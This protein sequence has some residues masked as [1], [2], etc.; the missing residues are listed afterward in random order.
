MSGRLRIH[1]GEVYDPANGVDGEVRD[2]LVEDGRIVAELPP[3]APVLDARGLVVFPG[4]VD[5]HCHITGP[6]VPLGRRLS[7]DRARGEPL[8]APELL[9]GE[10]RSGTGGVIPSSFA[11]GY[12]YAGL[13]YTSAVDAAVAPLGAHHA[14]AEL[15]DVPILDSGFLA[16]VGNNALLLDLLQKGERER[17]VETVGWIVRSAGALGI[18]AVNPGGVAA[19]KSGASNVEGLD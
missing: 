8:S 19:W 17:F 9:E 14:H 5:L 2:V 13:G 11:T 12:L 3:E 10:P 1:G 18:K 4:G 16:L 7:P 6:K 15:A